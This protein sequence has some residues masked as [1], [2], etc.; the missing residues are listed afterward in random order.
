MSAGGADSSGRCVRQKALVFVLSGPSGAGK[1]T[2]VARI[3]ERDPELRFSVSATTRGPRQTEQDGKDYYFLSVEEFQRRIDSGEFL[4]HALVHGAE[5]GTLR[6]EVQRS[7]DAS[8][9]V[10]LDVD[11]QGGIEIK[12]RMPEAVLVFL[13]PPTMQE[14][15]RRLRYRKTES[16]VKIQARLA[17]APAEIRCMDRYDYVVV[18]D[19][20]EPTEADLVAILNAERLRRER[21]TDDAGTP[22]VVG[23]YLREAEKPSHP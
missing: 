4:E 10:L 3:L 11:V 17:R 18:N 12:R 21:W 20:I 19:Q 22:D 5:Y 6:S 14:L 13:V 7:L 9:S 2:F 1:S 16:E 23:E 8:H 15:E